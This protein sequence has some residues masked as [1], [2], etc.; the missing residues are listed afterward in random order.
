[1]AQHS[2]NLTGTV[3]ATPDDLT[4]ISQ[5][6]DWSNGVIDVVGREGGQVFSLDDDG[7]GNGENS[8]YITG[9]GIYTTFP[10][11]G[12]IK[13][14]YEEFVPGAGEFGPF[15]AF[16][17]SANLSQ[18]YAAGFYSPDQIAVYR[19]N[20]AP[21]SVS[22]F[23]AGTITIT[24]P[25]VS[26]EVFVRVNLDGS[27]NFQLKYWEDGSSEPG[28]WTTVTET[29]TTYQSLRPGFFIQDG[30]VGTTY[31]DY[32]SSADNG[33]VAPLPSTGATAKKIY[34][35]YYRQLLAS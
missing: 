8:F 22:D 32:L 34:N 20:S 4:V 25:T 2:T 7:S 24:P 3:G 18:G 28:T 10:M 14:S 31:I 15:F 11:E 6:V 26:T 23:L 13:L 16:Y 12:L 29:D 19:F 30:G 21:G 5:D 17:N 27:G 33:D 9:A 1:M 35:R